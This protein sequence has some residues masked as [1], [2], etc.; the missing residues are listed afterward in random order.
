MTDSLW[1]YQGIGKT[2]QMFHLRWFSIPRFLDRDLRKMSGTMLRLY[3]MASMTASLGD[4]QAA[5]EGSIPMEVNMLITGLSRCC[6]IA[7]NTS[8][9]QD[10][11][12]VFNERANKSRPS[13]LRQLRP[14][15]VSSDPRGIFAKGV[16]SKPP[17]VERIHA[18]SIEPLT[19]RTIC[20]KILSEGLSS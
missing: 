2:G 14:L 3:T 11:N 13:R 12:K 10:K 6:C 5:F 17:G 19:Y 8:H 9:D 7:R 18:T 4:A 1:G 16:T 20:G 15:M